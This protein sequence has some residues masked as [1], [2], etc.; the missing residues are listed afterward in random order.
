MNEVLETRYARD[1]TAVGFKKKIISKFKSVVQFTIIII[2][3]MV[4]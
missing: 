2:Q 3:F 4:K 1:F